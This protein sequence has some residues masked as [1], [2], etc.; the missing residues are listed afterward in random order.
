[1]LT[2]ALAHLSAPAL[3]GL[4]LVLVFGGSV[5]GT[6]GLGLPLVS[7]PLATQFLDLPVAMGLLT[8]PL[9]ATNIGQAIEGGDTAAALTRLW[10]ALAGVVGG[11]VFGVHL[12]V[13][14]DRRLLYGAVGAVFIALAIG[15][16]LHPRLRLGPDKERW[17]GVVAGVLSGLLGGISG[18]FG[19][20]L[21]VYLVSLG[22]PPNAFVKYAAL[23]FTVATVTLMLALGGA[24]QLSGA[25]FLVSA[26]ATAPVG[27][28]M[29]GGRW[30]RQ[31][32]PPGLFR[33]AVLFVVAAG[34]LAM[35]RR[36]F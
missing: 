27:L 5:K 28:G 13:T 10:P 29:L 1:M 26:A 8:V 21:S 12:L 36:A 23:L 16:R 30:L 6:I 22:L 14:A 25:D 32:V 3:A 19:P 9:V 11:T 20:P 4:L 18:A 2:P 34:G 33:D 24:G 35:L 15:M 17:A 31:R 7:V